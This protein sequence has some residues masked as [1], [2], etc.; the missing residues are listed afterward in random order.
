M[1]KAIVL[2]IMW[3]WAKRKI[4]GRKGNN[5]SGFRVEM[6]RNGNL[7]TTQL[8]RVDQVICFDSTC[9]PIIFDD[10]RCHGYT[11]TPHLESNLI[12]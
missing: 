3:K 2:K 9:G 6:Y 10:V 12:K 11:L 1:W 7:I 4:T 5:F 8:G